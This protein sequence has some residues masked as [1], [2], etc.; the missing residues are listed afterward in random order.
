METAEAVHS[1]GATMLDAPVSGS[2]PHAEAGTLTIMVGGPEDAFARAEP[3]LHEAGEK[4]TRVGDNGQ[5]L[6]LKLAI[7]IS[8]A[9]QTLAFGEGLLMAERGGID[10]QLAAQVMSESPIGSPMLQG[11]VPLLLDASLPPWFDVRLMHKDI[12]VLGEKLR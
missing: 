7:N 1:A 9:A 10:P 8:I 12:A 3:L 5:G 11:R 4:V 6:L 2:V